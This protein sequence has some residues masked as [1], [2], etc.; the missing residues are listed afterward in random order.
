MCFALITPDGEKVGH[1]TLFSYQLL[2]RG[3]SVVDSSITYTNS[4]YDNVDEFVSMQQKLHF[5]D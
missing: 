1:W 4:S 2:L 5:L 3:C